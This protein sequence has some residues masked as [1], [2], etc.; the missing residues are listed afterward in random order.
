[1]NKIICI[2]V[3]FALFSCNE[4]DSDFVEINFNEL[5]KDVQYKFNEIYNYNDKTNTSYLP[6][7]SECAN[8]D[9]K[10]DCIIE[11]KYNSIITLF[12]PQKFV[13]STCEKTA[14]IPFSI[15]E[16]V[17]VVKND[18]VYYPFTLNGG[19]TTAGEARSFNIKIDTLKFH[20]KKM[21]DN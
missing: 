17:F 4:G 6:P 14:S 18:S 12:I 7:F 9:S 15:L 11:Y 20:I 3:L 19:A 16:P 8:V 21:K 2:L 5:P 13:V 1:M 10:C